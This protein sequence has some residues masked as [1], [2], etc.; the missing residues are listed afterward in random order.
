MVIF[1]LVLAEFRYH[2]GRFKIQKHKNVIVTNKEKD[3]KLRNQNAYFVNRKQRR[4]D[5]KHRACANRPRME[6]HN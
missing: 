1:T 5:K 4:L 3:E 6:E 2:C